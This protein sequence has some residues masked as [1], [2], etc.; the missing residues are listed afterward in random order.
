MA[1][2]FVTYSH[3]DAKFVDRLVADLESSGLTLVFD[4]RLM[5][6][7]DSLMR[8]FEEIGTVE[9]LLAVLSPSSVT[10]NWVTKELAGAVIREIEEPGFKVI[11]VI[12]EKCSL[13]TSI[14]QALRDKYQARFDQKKYEIAIGEILGA[15]SESD[16]ARN[17]YSEFQGP[18][19]DNPFRRVRAEHFES[20]STLARSYSEPEAARY[21]RI[22]ETKPVILEGAEGL[23]RP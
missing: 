10:S 8:I 1:R 14:R 22:M 18:S 6:P 7:G 11:P 17:L 5:R 2:A 21:E 16:D 13:P 20:I 3:Q 9:F 4:K 19:S 12:K 23:E 15:L